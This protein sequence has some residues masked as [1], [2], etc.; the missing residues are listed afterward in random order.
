MQ[1]AAVVITGA[2]Q[3]IGWLSNTDLCLVLDNDG[4]GAVILSKVFYVGIFILI[5]T[6]CSWILERYIPATSQEI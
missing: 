2:Q 3:G 5:F 6:R 4:C 1:D